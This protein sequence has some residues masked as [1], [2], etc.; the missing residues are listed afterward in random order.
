MT[1]AEIEEFRKMA[2]Q[3]DALYQ[4]VHRA[5]K[6]PDIWL[7]S[8]GENGENA[9]RRRKLMAILLLS[10]HFEM[11]EQLFSGHKL[12]TPRGVP[13]DWARYYASAGVTRIDRVT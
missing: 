11:A 13:I 1:E 8:H 12:L 5:R 4:E 9:S 10:F 6:H 3:L 7:T 2:A